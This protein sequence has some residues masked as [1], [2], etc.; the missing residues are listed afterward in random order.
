M[1]RSISVHDGVGFRRIPDV[2]RLLVL[3]SL[4]TIA[5]SFSW[6]EKLLQFFYMILR[7][8]FGRFV[9]EDFVVEVQDFDALVVSQSA[10]AA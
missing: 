6:V 8:F 1:L 4:N 9:R 2:N 10:A 7:D 5:F 3:K